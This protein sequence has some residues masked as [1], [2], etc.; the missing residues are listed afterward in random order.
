[1]GKEP[2]TARNLRAAH[3]YIELGMFVEAADEMECI[4]P[5][6]RI[7]PSV[8][9]CRYA[10]YAAMKKWDLAAATAGLMAKIFP[11]DHEWWV[12]WA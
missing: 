4:A 7:H 5:Q 8:V 11:G 10:I 2:D 12:H 6:D 3:G 1:M 9:P